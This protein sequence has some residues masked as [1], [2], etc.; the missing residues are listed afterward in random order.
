M[1]SEVTICNLGLSHLGES[2]T[3]VSID[4]PEGSMH[5]E[6]CAEFYPIAR[7]SLL[8]MHNWGFATRR[9]TL[10]ELAD[11]PSTAW[12]YA[13]SVPDEY[14]H[15]IALL[16]PG[17]ADTDPQPFELESDDDGNIILY[18]NTEDAIL[19]YV[20]RTAD[21]AKFTPLFVDTLGWLLASY[22]A[23]PI[24]KG[25]SGAAAGRECYRTAVG[26]LSRAA[27]SDASARRVEQMQTPSA[28]SAR[29]GALSP[30]LADGRIIR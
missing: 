16:A 1:A 5:A 28:I 30:F 7:D 17:G 25:D 12:A 23:G 18:T 26:Q 24:I 22:L 3:V 4:P 15:A 9:A 14:L 29:G 2:A 27:V 19:R 13:Y 21:T 8:E 10:A 6:K 20:R 11:P